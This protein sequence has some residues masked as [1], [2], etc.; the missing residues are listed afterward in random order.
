MPYGIFGPLVP[1][2]PSTVEEVSLP[3][4]DDAELSRKRAQQDYH[5]TNGQAAKRPR[6][7]NGYE[8][9]LSINTDTMPM[10]VDQANDQDHSSS[11]HNHDQ[12]VHD[13]HENHDNAYPSPIEIEQAPSPI[14]R[15]DGP[16]QGTQIDKVEELASQTTFVELVDDLMEPQSPMV[17]GTGPG[18]GAGVE[19]PPILLQCEWNPINPSLLAGAGTDALGRVWTVSRPTGPAT[20][21][22]D[23]VPPS[24]VML[25][26]PEWPRDTTVTALAWASDGNTIAVATDQDSP[27]ITIW[28]TDGS[29][30]QDI[31]V[32]DGPILKLSWNPSNTALLAITSDEKGGVVTVHYPPTGLSSSYAI[33]EDR[34]FDF[35]GNLD[36][37][38]ESDWGVVI[39]AGKDII[40]LSCA[41]DSTQAYFRSISSIAATRERKDYMVQ[42][43][44]D[45]HSNLMAT[46]S[47]AG[48]LDVSDMRGSPITRLMGLGL[49]VSQENMDSI[50]ARRAY[51]YYG[52]AAASFDT[53][54]RRQTAHCHR[55]RGRFHTYLECP[56]VRPGAH[57]HLHHGRPGPAPSVHPRWSF[58]CRGHIKPGPDMEGRKL[59]PAASQLVSSGRAGVA[60]SAVSVGV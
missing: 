44:I 60:E 13:T 50:R 43:A 24:R 12:H 18:A 38:W 1:H 8:N 33:S 21:D 6:L 3:E 57:V 56:R 31:N 46:S 20:P 5:M 23:H 47:E 45:R 51:Y 41:N 15:T 28:T 54:N 19:N 17:T 40:V 4:V 9:G 53:S 30:V 35:N 7:S 52:L 2:Q 25:V 59:D 48:Y 22:Q 16:E 32:D 14:S 10:D 42:V 39:C 37:T 29:H 49:G 55:R 26:A 34:G 11:D 36:A 58:H 27:K